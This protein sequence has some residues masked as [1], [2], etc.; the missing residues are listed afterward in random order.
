[1]RPSPGPRWARWPR[2]ARVADVHG[3]DAEVI[4]GTSVP[5]ASI[6][7]CLALARST[8]PRSNARASVRL[9][10]H[11]TAA[12]LDFAGSFGDHIRKYTAAATLDEEVL[13]VGS[14]RHAD[15][16]RSGFGASS[17]FSPVARV[18]QRGRGAR[19]VVG[20]ADRQ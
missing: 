14:S 12:S 18:A 1:M 10:A 7:Q 19:D 3:L 13:L 20:R 5:S 4:T 6:C 16:E 8:M 15:V 9:G 17:T 11:Q 2:L